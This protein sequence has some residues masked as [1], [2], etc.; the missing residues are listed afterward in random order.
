MPA[1]GIAGLIKAALAVHHGVR[2]PTLH[3]EEPH[4]ALAPTRFRPITELEPWDRATAATPRR[5]AV[6]AFGFGG[7]NAHVVLEEAPGWRTVAAADRTGAGHHGAGG[8]GAAPRR[9][10]RRRAVPPAGRTRTTSCWPR[11]RSHRRAPRP[12]R[13]AWRSSS[14]P[15]RTLALARKVVARGTPWQGR[16]DVW[17][18][19]DP[20]LVNPTRKIAFL[21]PGFEPEFEPRVDDVA[22][23]FR[24]ARPHLSG[25]DEL[26]ERS[27]DIIAVGRLLADALGRIGVTPDVMAGHSLGEWTAMIASGLYERDGDRRVRGHPPPRRRRRA[28]PRLRRPRLRRRPGRGR[29]R[30]PPRHRPL[31]RQLP[32]PVGDLRH[33][34]LGRHRRRAA[35]GR[36]G[37]GPA[38]AVP[39]GLPLADARPLPGPGAGLVRPPPPPPP[40]GAG[41]VGH[42]R[43]PL[44]RRPR[45]RPR[46]RHPPPAGAGAVRPPHPPPP[47]RGRAGLRPGR[48]RQPARLRRRHPRGTS[49]TWR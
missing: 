29:H 1:A 37:H 9:V 10:D 30:R 27:L 12:G 28:R 34:P 6:N 4:P 26:V 3:V 17:F 5:A 24:L 46:P 47:R 33:P 11:R 42:H 14:P 36:P 35:A 22:D 39:V 23:H 13:C 44:P 18:T 8:A 21:F 20:L 43:Q 19:A 16:S 48:P 40:V 32:P 31:P 7:I 15:T 25:G 38:H 49:P 2:P 45:R 41:V